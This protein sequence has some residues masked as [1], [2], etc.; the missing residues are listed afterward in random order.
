MMAP[1]QVRKTKITWTQIGGPMGLWYSQP[2]FVADYR[3]VD[4]TI[5]GTGDLQVL[6]T[7]EL[8]NSNID[9][10]VDFTVTST[11]DNS[12]AAEVIADLTIPNTYVTTLTVTGSTKLAE[13]NDNLATF[14]CLTRSIDTVDAFVTYCDNS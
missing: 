2:I 7:K 10:P 12:W 13:L 14:I 5:V 9:T 6:V 8:Y 3:D 1:R 4:I 11:I